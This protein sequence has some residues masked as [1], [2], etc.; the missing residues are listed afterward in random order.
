M[1]LSDQLLNKLACPQ[2]KKGLVFEK[3]KTKL[4]CNE[5]KLAYRVTNNIPVLLLDEAEK[6]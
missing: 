4:I 3:E 5:C 6:L 1:T 2:C